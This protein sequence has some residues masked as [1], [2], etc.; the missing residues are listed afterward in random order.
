MDN[1]WIEG[2]K[3]KYCFGDGDFIAIEELFDLHKKFLSEIYESLKND[4]KELK[5]DSSVDNNDNPN[6]HELEVKIEIIKAVLD[7]KKDE[8]L[9]VD[10]EY[11]WRLRKYPGGKEMYIPLE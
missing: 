6:I 8:E 7:T 3:N 4:L 9:T 2:L 11:N 1:I 5:E 10:D